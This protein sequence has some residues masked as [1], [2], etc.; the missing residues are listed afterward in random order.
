MH[1]GNAHRDWSIY[2]RPSPAVLRCL[3]GFVC[4]VSCDKSILV[5]SV[6]RS[7]S[8]LCPSFLERAIRLVGSRV[9]FAPQRC[10]LSQILFTVIGSSTCHLC[11]TAIWGPIPPP[12]EGCWSIFVLNARLFPR[13]AKVSARMCLCWKNVHLFC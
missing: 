8:L 3:H 1:F 10:C 2:V 11:S 5:A 9:T 4:F 7:L 13:R 6:S 12:G